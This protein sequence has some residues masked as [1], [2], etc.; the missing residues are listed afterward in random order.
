MEW[1]WVEW[2]GAQRKGSSQVHLVIELIGE[3]EGGG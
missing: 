2:G 1:G 3:L